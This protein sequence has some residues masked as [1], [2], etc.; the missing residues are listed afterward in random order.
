MLF[1]VFCLVSG[2]ATLN[3]IVNHK[4]F[5]KSSRRSQDHQRVTRPTCYNSE[6]LLKSRR[7]VSDPLSSDRNVTGRSYGTVTM[8]G[9]KVHNSRAILS[10]LK[11]VSSAIYM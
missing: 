10:L 1:F 9:T 6:T 5:L 7:G 11:F 2:V 4:F 3:V 8:K